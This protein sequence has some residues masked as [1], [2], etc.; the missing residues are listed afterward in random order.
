MQKWHG[1]WRLTGTERGILLEA[2]V[3]LV[4]T[5]LGLRL[6]GFRRWNLLLSR[7]APAR[8]E[9]GALPPSLLVSA[10]LLARM[11][12]AAARNLFYPASCLERSMVL[13]WLLRTRGI[14]AELRVGAHKDADRFEAHAWVECAGIV[15][16][17]ADDVHVHFVPFDEPISSPETASH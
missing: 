6:S 12:S 15:L 5:W 10:R 17:E 13:C 2:T 9:K 14:P 8:A 4:V 11:E 3:A 7:L 16:N 1:F